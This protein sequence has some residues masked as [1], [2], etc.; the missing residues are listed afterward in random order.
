MQYRNVIRRLPAMFSCWNDAVNYLKNWTKK[1]IQY[2]DQKWMS[3][4]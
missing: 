3:S 2:F 1:R 4:N